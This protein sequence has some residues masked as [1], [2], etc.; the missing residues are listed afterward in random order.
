M[1]TYQL[2]GLKKV[3]TC[4]LCLTIFVGQA[5]ILNP[6]NVLK[7]KLEQK[8]NDKLEKKINDKVDQKLDEKIGKIVDFD[9]KPK[10]S[11]AFASSVLQK[12][13]VVNKSKTETSYM[14]VLFSK[15]PTAV[16]VLLLDKNQA[17]DSAKGTMIMDLEQK[18][19]FTFGVDKKG[20]K[21]Y[22]GF[23]LKE[24]PVQEADKNATT[25]K[26]EKTFT[27]TGKTKTIMGYTCEGYQ[28]DGDNGD[29]FIMWVTTSSVAGMND[30]AKAMQQYSLQ[31]RQ[32]QTTV[33]ST[34]IETWSKEGKAVLGHD[35]ISK[36]GDQ[37]LT[38]L[39]KIS[40][41][42]PSNFSTEG[43]KSSFEK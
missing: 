42:D 38:E 14:K 37:M 28:M 24:Q 40:P 18:A 43:Y 25:P 21:N 15:E 23:H 7:R 12:M 36:N 10:S 29:T 33:F 5:Q 27:K 35:H 20:N 41:D 30:Y 1:K 8:I 3:V 11:Y 26:P 19:F 39:E 6:T 2:N 32:K 16:S 31:Q 9:V 34:N 4:F 22:F 17:S 13:T